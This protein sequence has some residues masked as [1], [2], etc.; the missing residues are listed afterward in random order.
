MQGL[1]QQVPLTLHMALERAATLYPSKTVTTKTASGFH[2]ETYGELAERVARLASALKELG[3]KPGDRVA[4]AAWN[5]YRHLELYLAVPCM[6]AV[7]HTLNFRLHPD[8]IAYIANHAEDQIVFADASISAI[9]QK[10]GE[11]KTVREVV[12][13]DDVDGMSLADHG[14]DYE[15]LVASGSPDFAWPRLDENDAAAMCY[16]SGTTG[17]PKGVVYAHRS[18]VLHALATL[19]ADSLAL[20]ER[21][22]CLP[23]V[24][25][26][27]SNAWGTPYGALLSG[28]SLAMTGRFMDPMSVTQLVHEA[29]VTCSAAVPTVWFGVLQAINAGQVDPSTLATLERIICG[30]AAVPE[31]LMHGFDKLGIPIIHGWGM[32]ETSPVGTVAAVKSTVPGD[33]VLRTRLTQ[34]I[35]LPTLKVRHVDDAGEVQPW[36]GESMGELQICGPWI[37]DAYYDPEAADGRGG[38][39]RFCDDEAGNRWLKTGDVAV[40]DSE[41]YVQLVDRT[42]DLVKSGGE[43]ISTV[44]LENL[45]MAHP[46]VTEAAVIAAPHPKWGERPLA[47]VVPGDRCV[48]KEELIGHL[49][50]HLAKWQ[51]PDDVIFIEEVPKTSVGKFDKQILRDRY[52]NYQLPTR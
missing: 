39:D 51:L 11:L 9:W 25:Q 52:A 5:S 17:T 41:G 49:A 26:F 7:L 38:L 29:G 23:I 50:E 12:W 15:Q 34:G 31:V 27:H 2:R 30:G 48:T 32:T 33:Q 37:A 46:K 14:L 47:C 18:S 45:L 24:P 35:P 10:L 28:A 16:T 13:M 36:D 19:F 42:K 4:T 40:I 8:Q 20:C 3:I 1:M 22:V 43:W 6:G 21:E 44:E